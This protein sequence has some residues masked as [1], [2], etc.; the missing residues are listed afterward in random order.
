M[1][2]SKIDIVQETTMRLILYNRP[3]RDWYCTQDR[4][5]IDIVHGLWWK[6]E[7]GRKRAVWCI[8]VMC[9][10]Q[11]KCNTGF[12]VRVMKRSK[13]LWLCNNVKAFCRLQW[14]KQGN[15]DGRITLWPTVIGS[16]PSFNASMIPVYGSKHKSAWCSQI[17]H[18]FKCS[19]ASHISTMYSWKR[20]ALQK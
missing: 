10:V 15:L 19:A 13:L 14:M 2:G 12:A 8:C 6:E 3:L 5:K 1:H 20:T 18:N 4:Y 17:Q 9:E 11:L 7:R 16:S